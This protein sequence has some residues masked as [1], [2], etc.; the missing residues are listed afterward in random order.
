LGVSFGTGLGFG[1]LMTV[2]TEI[3]KT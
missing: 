2:L 3:L 1:L